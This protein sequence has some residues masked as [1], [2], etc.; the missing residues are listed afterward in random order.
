MNIYIYT[1]KKHGIPFFVGVNHLLIMHR[2]E[3]HKTLS[4][5]SPS[6]SLRELPNCG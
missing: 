3:Q 4:R 2:S 6:K 5:L 1:I